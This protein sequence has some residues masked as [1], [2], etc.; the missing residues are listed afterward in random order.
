MK[1]KKLTEQDIAERKVAL[2]AASSFKEVATK[3][4]ISSTGV[5]LWKK[6]PALKES[7]E[8]LA[9]RSAELRTTIK[10]TPKPPVEQHEKL[11]DPGTTKTIILGFKGNVTFM[12][13]PMF[14][15]FSIKEGNA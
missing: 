14:V 9:K 12:G 1:G 6:N 13:K 3:F 10:P 11:K 2:D 15:D 5:Q 7:V 4:G 8:A